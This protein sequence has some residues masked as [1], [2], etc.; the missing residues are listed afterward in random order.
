MESPGAADRPDPVGVLPGAGR[1]QG[2]VDAENTPCA[3]ACGAQAPP[4]IRQTAAPS[5]LLCRRMKYRHAH[6]AGNFA[7]VHKHVTLLALLVALQRKD[8]GFLYLETHAG[9]GTYDLADSAEAGAGIA[10]LEGAQCAAPELRHYLERLAQARRECGSSRLYP[11]S[12][13]LAA[14]QLRAQDRGVFVE[15]LPEEARA[16]RRALSCARD[17][18]V[19]IETGD[20]FE[21]L[22]AVLPPP[23]R[24]ALTL[25]D[26]PYEQTR[27]DFERVR[28][29][30]AEALR[31]FP[32]GVV[33]VWYPVKDARDTERWLAAVAR[34]SERAALVAEL[35]LHPRDS[36]VALN[37]SGMLIVNPPY[38]LDAP[39]RAW[40]AELYGRLGGA[41]AGGSAVRPL[42]PERPA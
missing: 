20:G 40:L 30:I 27:R 36:R 3:A 11:G 23:E 38:Q 21:R 19:R 32:T 34:Q 41:A 42:A 18:P 29:G 16:L 25:I 24:R 39:M 22:R 2:P 35:W 15:A 4:G 37:G 5:L 9:R 10:R 14:R 8:K 7:D 31:R 17:A 33:A 1:P 13:W 6:H 26:P 12:P 28:A